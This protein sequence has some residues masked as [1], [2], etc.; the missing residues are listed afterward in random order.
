MDHWTALSP[1]FNPTAKKMALDS[2]EHAND[3]KNRENW[4]YSIYANK[5]Q[6]VLDMNIIFYQELKKLRWENYLK[7]VNAYSQLRP[8]LPGDMAVWDGLDTD[9]VI[10]VRVSLPSGPRGKKYYKKIIDSLKDFSPKPSPLRVD[11]DESRGSI[12]FDFP[13]FKYS[14]CNLNRWFWKND[15]PEDVIDFMKKEG[16]GLDSDEFYFF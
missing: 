11:G 1:K 5:K 9:G 14:L 4:P 6:G 3:L 15:L 16:K 10:E 7:M 13:L 2:D 8:S 12:R